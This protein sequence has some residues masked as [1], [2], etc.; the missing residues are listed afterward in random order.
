MRVLELG[1]QP[2]GAALELQLR[3]VAARRAGE[4]PDTLLLLE[5][6][7]VITCG[8]GTRV[9][10]ILADEETL[11]ARGIEVVEVG[12]GGDVTFHGPGQLVGYPI[13]DLRAEGNDVHR[14]LRNL[15]EALIRAL[16]R[17]GVDAGRVP[18][19]TGVWV[20]NEKVAAIGVGVKRWV[21]YHG[22]ALN[23]DVDLGDFDLIVPCGL[24][25]RGVTSLARLLPEP[26]PMAAVAQ[27]VSE[28]VAA[29]F[30]R[31]V[32]P[33]APALEVPV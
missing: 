14:F 7:A 8:R 20:G 12:R 26:P 29:V 17:F 2:Y 4:I 19:L 10:H 18:E 21:S 31:R 9:G 6:P 24:H 1:V 5:H 11:A 23:V 16:A 3:L 28:E 30:G 25:G 32:V 33:A 15:E 22:F 13:F 27:A